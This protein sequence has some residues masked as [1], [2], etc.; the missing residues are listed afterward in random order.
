MADEVV[1]AA[2]A[3][4]IVGRQDGVEVPP[5]ERIVREPPAHWVGIGEAGQRV[6]VGIDAGRVEGGIDDA[7][8]VV[9]AQEGLLS[10]LAPT[11]MLLMPFT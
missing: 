9:L 6:A 3:G 11:L 8:L 10:R 5:I 4:Q 2:A 7:E 1:L